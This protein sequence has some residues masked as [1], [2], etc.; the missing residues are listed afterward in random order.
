MTAPPDSASE[1]RWPFRTLVR[2]Y[3]LA[4]AGIAVCFPPLLFTEW[5]ASVVVILGGLSAL[6]A[7]LAW[8]TLAR[9]RAVVRLDDDAIARD[10]RKIA[11]WE[12]SAVTLRRYGGRR[13]TKDGGGIMEL[14]LS[15]GTARIG[16]DSRITDFLPLARRVHR[17]A[18]KNGAAM[19]EKT[20]AAFAALG[21]SS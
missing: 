16:V 5:T 3:V 18:R 2:D 17:A 1:H 12:I 10:G 4:A 6:F 19:D 15:G 9:Q 13:E 14:T 7:W 21:C 20:R 8:R 11:W